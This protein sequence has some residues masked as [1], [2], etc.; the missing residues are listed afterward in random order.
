MHKKPTPKQQ[1][2]NLTKTL[3]PAWGKRGPTPQNLYMLV[4]VKMYLVW[5]AS[6]KQKKRSTHAS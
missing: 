3:P 4:L 2:E 5:H 1:I 6:T